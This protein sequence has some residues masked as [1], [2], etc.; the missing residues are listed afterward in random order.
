[1]TVKLSRDTHKVFELAF[2]CR[3]KQGSR[4]KNYCNIFIFVTMNN[5]PLTIFAAAGWFVSDLDGNT[6]DRFSCD[7]VH[8]KSEKYY[9]HSL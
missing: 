3:T 6:K 2:F 4:D 1:M 9:K 8:V 5:K 7:M